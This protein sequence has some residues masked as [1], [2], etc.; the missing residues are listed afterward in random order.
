MQL[1]NNRTKKKT[2]MVAPKSPSRREAF[3]LKD[4]RMEDV[5]LLEKEEED[6]DD[7]ETRKRTTR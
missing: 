1:E 3:P 2:K 7:D 6:D 5:I 4:L